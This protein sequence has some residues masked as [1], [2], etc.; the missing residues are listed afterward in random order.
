MFILGFDA[1]KD[2]QSNAWIDGTCYSRIKEIKE[3]C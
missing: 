3:D 2:I 1:W